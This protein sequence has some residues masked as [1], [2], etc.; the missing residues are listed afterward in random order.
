MSEKLLIMGVSGCGK[1][2]IA[3]HLAA[4]LGGTCIEGDDYHLPASKKKM[5]HS[6]P[7]DDADRLPWLDQLGELLSKQTCDAVLTCSALKHMYRA[8]LRAAVPS[9]RIVFIDIGRDDARARVA[10]RPGHI[11]PASLV[12][13]QFRALESP[14]SEPGVLRIDA[15]EP[16]TVQVRTVLAWLDHAAVPY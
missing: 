9:L 1:S 16:V 6:T 2:T 3:G 5:Q 7:L 10:S 13:S 11:F 4:A 15:L 14:I 12:D 8:R